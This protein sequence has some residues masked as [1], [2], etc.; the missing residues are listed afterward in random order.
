MFTNRALKSEYG[1]FYLSDSTDV[2]ECLED[3]S[4]ADLHTH[5]ANCKKNPGHT[6][7]IPVNEFS[8]MHLPDRYQDKIVYKLTKTMAD[9]TVRIACNF[10]SPGRP[11][12]VPGTKY[13][14]PCYKTRGQKSLK[15]GTGGIR[16]VKHCVTDQTTNS[17]CPCPTC[18][19]G[20]NTPREE[21]WCVKVITVSHVVFDEEEAR[22]SSCRLWFDDD[23]SPMVTLSGLTICKS[24]SDLDW[25][26]FYCVTHDK[27]LAD[28]IEKKL[29][30]F[31]DVCLELRDKYRSLRDVDKLTIIVALV[32]LYQIL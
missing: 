6:E 17:H 30:A 9:I 32:R 15:T 26:S 4:E 3:E 7:F 21:W 28:K 23:E 1:H 25:C 24:M 13:P 29:K 16:G 12:F 19:N 2:Q 5:L 14:Y 10:T 18:S 20:S 8:I 22:Q 27:E 31:Y 11:E